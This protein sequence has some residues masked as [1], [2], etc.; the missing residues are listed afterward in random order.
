MSRAASDMELIHH[1]IDLSWAVVGI[2]ENGVKGQ[3]SDIYKIQNLKYKQQL[4][5]LFFDDADFLYLVVFL[6]DNFFV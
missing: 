4:S 3:E 5:A 6:H 2:C 1:Y